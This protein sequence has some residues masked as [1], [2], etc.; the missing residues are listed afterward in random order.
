VIKIGLYRERP[1]SFCCVLLSNFFRLLFVV[2][3]LMLPWSGINF[4][5]LIDIHLLKIMI[6]SGVYLQTVNKSLTRKATL[7][8]NKTRIKVQSQ[9]TRIRNQPF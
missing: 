8:N 6:L 1:F 9:D 7:L 5:C 3:I 2:A 4:L